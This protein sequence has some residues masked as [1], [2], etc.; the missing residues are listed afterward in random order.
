MKTLLVIVL[1]IAHAA[2]H[3][4]DSP[5]ADAVRKL[6][7][8]ERL[9]VLNEDLAALTNLWA[10]EFI[11]HNPQNRVSD[12]RDAV[13]AR[14]KEGLIRYSRFE[15]TIDLVRVEGDLAF[16]MGG[17]LVVP[18]REPATEVHRRFTNVW[19]RTG[20]TWRMIARQA[21]IVAR[22]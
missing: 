8:A 7:D 20:D 18:K 9:A 4:A 17:E 11:V 13:L 16:V 21:T 12:G 14:M 10:P 19:R 6:D 3:A 1:L 2:V 15:R 5:D 22:E